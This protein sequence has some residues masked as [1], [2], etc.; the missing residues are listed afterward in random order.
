VAGFRALILTG[1][2]VVGSVVPGTPATAQERRD[3]GTMV[4]AADVR[5]APGPRASVL[6]T[7][8]AG[9][10]VFVLEMRGADARI[11][12]AG[13][14]G[15]T[16]TGWVTA[17]RIRLG[18]APAAPGT[19]SGGGSSFLRGIAGFLGGGGG[20]DQAMVPIGVRG[21]RAEDVANAQ[22]DPGA[23]DALDRFATPTRE[24]LAFARSQGLSSRVYD[25]G[26]GAAAPV[27]DEKQ[28][29]NDR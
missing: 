10:R 18:A 8:P 7:L 28:W 14:P 12:A 22:P 2:L 16:L 6:F 21:L 24:A 27:G 5:E 20:G 13:A 23:V 3:P 25:Y 15:R 19:T 29:G 26:A 9:A 1:T 17:S 11:E 4:L